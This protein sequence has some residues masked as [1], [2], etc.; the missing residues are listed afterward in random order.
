MSKFEGPELVDELRNVK[1]PRIIVT[2]K[3]IDLLKEANSSDFYV[4]GLENL[5][6]YETSNDGTRAPTNSMR[7]NEETLLFTRALQETERNKASSQ[8][9]QH[10]FKG[11]KSSQ[12]NYKRC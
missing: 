6:T 1:G 9:A 4:R 10:Q 5:V 8:S 11:H 7:E 12:P 3:R 2:M